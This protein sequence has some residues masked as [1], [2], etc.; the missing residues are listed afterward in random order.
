MRSFALRLARCL[1]IGL[2]VVLACGCQTEWAGRSDSW[3]RISDSVWASM[4]DCR[5]YAVVRGDR[6]LLIDTCL[7]LDLQT[8]SKI[9]V[10]K[11]DAI[12]HTDYHRDL[13]ASDSKV[14]SSDTRIFA[15][16]LALPLFGQPHLFW[17]QWKFAHQYTFQWLYAP[18]APVAVTDPMDVGGAF[19]WQGIR[20][21][22]LPTP[23][24]SAASTSILATVDGL[25]LAFSGDLIFAPGKIRNIHELQWLYMDNS[26]IGK[27]AASLG[28]VAA[29]KPDRLCPSHGKI[30]ESPQQAIAQTVD[31][32]KRLPR[33]TNPAFS[34]EKTR[35]KGWKQFSEHLWYQ[36]WHMG[37]GMALV[38]DGHA[39]LIDAPMELLWD[40]LR[41]KSGAQSVDAIVP[42]HYHDDHA[43][44]LSSLRKEHGAK[45]WI[46]QSFADILEHPDHYDL[47]C[48]P[49]RA[50]KADRVLVDGESIDW[51]GIR[52]TCTRL[53][54]QT[55]YHA[56]FYGDIDGRK[57]FFVG[58]SLHDINFRNR[59]SL[60]EGE[61][62]DYVFN[63]LVEVRPDLLFHAHQGP[64]PVTPDDLRNFGAW[65]KRVRDALTELL[66]GPNPNFHADPH[67]VM[68]SPFHAKGKPGESFELTARVHNYLDAPMLVQCK[69]VAPQGW[70]P[71]KEDWT[72]ATVAAG[73]TGQ[74]TLSVTIP[75]QAK[76]GRSVVGLRVKTDW[77]FD[78][79]PAVAIVDVE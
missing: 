39:L 66:P 17:Q 31:K 6:A 52:L 65:Q 41:E 14:A 2:V 77:G 4:G 71:P 56:G 74:V 1:V 55:L 79:I 7:D 40:E 19:D 33:M 63:K 58:D 47:P 49:A 13:C 15:G 24:R 10:A 37:V 28:R 45:L 51:R 59:V 72:K 18:L 34:A 29:Y 48:L 43:Q 76:P 62:N 42:T 36:T 57:V 27:T 69:T 25:R 67:W 5:A 44:A 21:E 53:P 16:I 50:A 68:A 61:G 22:F 12:L 54:G 20:F 26:G 60:N 75:T 8:L 78:G 64:I 11:V 23:G 9:G 73:Q 35:E 30:M 32:L 38:K 70:P 46:F 3:E